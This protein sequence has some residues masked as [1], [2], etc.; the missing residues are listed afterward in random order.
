MAILVCSWLFVMMFGADAD[1][2]KWYLPQSIGGLL[3]RRHQGDDD[4]EPSREW[5]QEIAQIR[6][7]KKTGSK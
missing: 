6:R 5:P 7:M 4:V 3:I 1:L 2:L